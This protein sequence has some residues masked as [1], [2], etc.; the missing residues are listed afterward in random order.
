MCVSHLMYSLK[1]EHT[2]VIKARMVN[3]FFNV[4][5]KGVF[6]DVGLSILKAL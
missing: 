2:T 4:L 3:H 6:L 1:N 5:L